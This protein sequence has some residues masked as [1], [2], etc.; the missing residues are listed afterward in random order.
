[1]FGGEH[2]YEGLSVEGVRP[3][4]LTAVIIGVVF[5][6]RHHVLSGGGG[7][8][9]YIMQDLFLSGF[10]GY[11]ISRMQHTLYDIC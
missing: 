11:L 3:T 2:D 6:H 10:R 5:S 9:I 4:G 8:T 1:M 7:A